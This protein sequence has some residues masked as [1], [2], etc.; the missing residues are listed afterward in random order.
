[1]SLNNLLIVGRFTLHGS[2]Y[3]QV[4]MLGLSAQPAVRV[5]KNVSDAYK[6]RTANLKAG[7]YGRPGSKR[8]AGMADSAVRFRPLAAQPFDNRACRGNS[9]RRPCR[10]GRSRAE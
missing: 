7:N 4:K 8:Y 1:M 2:V 9:A 3:S 10:S 6:T 5:I